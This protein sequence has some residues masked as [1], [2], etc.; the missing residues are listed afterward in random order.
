MS[1]E[2]FDAISKEIGAEIMDAR[3]AFEAA[4]LEEKN[5]TKEARDDDRMDQ[6]ENPDE[7]EQ[8]KEGIEKYNLDAYDEDLPA[9]KAGAF[10]IV[11][12][13]NSGFRKD[14]WA[15]VS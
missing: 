1:Q 6:E 12:S 3:L 15:S 8:E 10:N 7:L 2:E 14:S 5:D 9:G 4:S 13:R 11:I